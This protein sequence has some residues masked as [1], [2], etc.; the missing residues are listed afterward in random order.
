MTT[1]VITISNSLETCDNYSPVLLFLLLMSTASQ[2]ELSISDLFRGDLQLASPPNIY[3]KLK[4]IVNEPNKTIDDVAFIIEKD[5]SLTLRILKVVNSAFYGFPSKITSINRAINLIGTRELQSIVLS[6]TVMDRFSDL[7]GHL[8][9]MHDFWAKNLR[10][11]LIA[12]GIDHH[13]DNRY[14]DSIFICGLL[15]NIG[16]LVFFRRIPELARKVSLLLEA[17]EKPTDAT[18]IGIEQR[19][20]GF[21]HYQAGAELIK[22]WKLPEIISESIKL[23]PFPENTEK[24]HKIASIIRLANSYSPLDFECEDEIIDDLNINAT[25]LNEIIETAHDQFEEIFS[26]FYPG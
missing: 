25:D 6:T 23:H 1:K 21:N 20:I 19:V 8:I 2:N 17:Q 18:E 26:V 12:R 22:L 11:A 3:F 9:S 10:C 5:A 16:Q 4:E 7:P 15:H 13:L 14:V 24:N